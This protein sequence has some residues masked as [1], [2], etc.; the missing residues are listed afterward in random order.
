[1]NY[2]YIVKCGVDTYKI[3]ITQN[4]Q[5]RISAL[6][7]SNAKE[8]KIVVARVVKNTLAFEQFLHSE[9][10]EFRTN[11]GTEWFKLNSTQVIDICIKIFEVEGFEKDIKKHQQKEMKRDLLCVRRTQIKILDSISATNKNINLLFNEKSIFKLPQ[12]KGTKIKDNSDSILVEQAKMIILEEN[13]VSVS[14]LQR[15][16]K[17][18]YVRAAR[19]VDLLEKDKIVSP[20]DGSN[21]RTIFKDK[22]FKTGLIDKR[23]R[24][25]S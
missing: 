25:V 21:S 18:G 13:R 16:L 14:L 12:T 1:M 8:V 15:K 20:W 2:L 4:L 17:I 3:G 24:K 11:G 5:N 7:T 6:R 9:Y 10:S 22:L 19:I 23:K